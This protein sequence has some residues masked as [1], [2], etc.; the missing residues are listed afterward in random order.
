MYKMASQPFTGINQK[1]LVFAQV[2]NGTS[3]AEENTARICVAPEKL[4]ISEKDSIRRQFSSLMQLHKKV[5][6]F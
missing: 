6:T 3:S 2:R 1:P 4:T 5:N